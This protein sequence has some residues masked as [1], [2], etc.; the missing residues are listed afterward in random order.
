MSNNNIIHF[1]NPYR[2][3]QIYISIFITVLT[4]LWVQI[5]MQH[6]APF[7]RASQ[8]F[9][10]ELILEHDSQDIYEGADVIYWR[11]GEYYDFT[12]IK[13]VY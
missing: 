11:V 3:R 2:N 9:F 1:Q 8:C 13:G 4:T 7:V 12:K 5:T 6:Y 10:N